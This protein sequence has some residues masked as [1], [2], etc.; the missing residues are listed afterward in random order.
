MLKSGDL[1]RVKYVWAIEEKISEIAKT[2]GVNL[3]K[4]ASILESL[5]VI[6]SGLSNMQSN[7]NA[8]SAATRETMEIIREADAN[9]KKLA[10]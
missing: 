7:L 5:N 4:N 2:L 1:R 3:P 9:I 8:I 6:Q 10:C